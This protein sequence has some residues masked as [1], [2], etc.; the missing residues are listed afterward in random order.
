[1]GSPPA[2]VGL[3]TRNCASCTALS[4]HD[5]LGPMDKWKAT[6]MVLVGM[7]LGLGYSAACS[8]AGGGSGGPSLG[9][10][11]VAMAQGSGCDQW[12]V[13]SVNVTSFA[14]GSSVPVV[15]GGVPYSANVL[16]LG[17]VP[18]GGSGNTVGLWAARCVQ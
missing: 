12:E 4:V 16:P 9:G 14:D 13:V 7:V 1:M 15:D 2:W 5:T 18:L 8:S 6:C 10:P 3:Y 17:W 11:G